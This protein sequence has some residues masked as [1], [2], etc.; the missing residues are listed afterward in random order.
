MSNELRQKLEVILAS[1][2][3]N[4]GANK[5]FWRIQPRDDEGQWIEMGA[6]VLFRFRTGDGNLVVATG[7][8]VYVGPS[9]K[10]GRARVMIEEGND[11]GLEPGIYD[12]E[13]RNLQQFQALLPE[14][15]V[16]EG[17][18]ERK[19]KFGRPVK[20]LADG[21]LPALND[22]LQNR[23]PITEEDRRLGRGELTP[24]EREAEADGREKSPIANLP[25]GFEAENPE[26][27]K[28][29]LR[30]SGVDPDEFDQEVESV[31]QAPKQLDPIDTAVQDAYVNAFDPT[32]EPPSLD[33]V[34]EKSKIKPTKP[35]NLNIGDVVV[36]RDGKNPG[37]ILGLNLDPSGGAQPSMRLQLEDGRII[38]APLDLK[39]E[40]NVVRDRVAK[41]S[42]PARPAAREESPAEVQEPE[43]VDVPETT[44]AD[45]T[46][47]PEAPTEIAP[48]GRRIDD[49]ET[50]ERQ[51][52]T[53]EQLEELRKTK[54]APLIDENGEAV[55]E[56][57]EKGKVRQPRDPNAMLN[58][59]ADTYKNSKFNDR[60][61]LVLMRETSRENGKNI[62]WEIR[63]AITGDKKI[64]YIFNF[65]N[66]DTGEEQTLLH[67][68]ARDSV[69]SLMGKTNSPEVLAD[70]LTGKQ[71]RKY[72]PTFDTAVHAKDVLER[73]L[74]F[75]YQGRTKS[76][77]DSAKYYSIGYAERVNPVNGTLLEKEVP[78]VFDAYSSKDKD[79]LASRLRAVF[80]GL[81]VDEQTHEE[82][83][84]A[85]RELFAERFPDEDKRQFGIAVTMA[86]RS[87]QKGL[88]DSPENRAV[89]WSSKDK[90][91]SLD[92]GQTVE[93]KNN[94][95]E[96]SI[97][98]VVGKQKVNTA[99][100]AQS[101]DI[102][103][104][105]DYVTVIDADGKRTSLPSTSLAILRDQSTALTSYKGRVSGARLREERGVFYTPGT[106]KF[107]GQTSIPD[108]ISKVDDLV[109]GDNFYNR[110]GVNLGTV[111]E[112][113]PIVGKDDKKGY[114]ILY[115]NRDGELRKAAVA[116]G[117]ER[118]PR[119][120]TSN[121]ESPTPTRQVVPDIEESDPDFDLD[122][123]EFQTD[124][125]TV[126]RPKSVGLD[127][128]VPANSKRNAEQQLALN[129]EVQ[130]EIDEMTSS[131]RD[132][133]TGWEYDSS[134]LSAK[135]FFNAG[136]LALL[137]ENA[138]A[139]YPDLTDSEIRTLLEL[140]HSKQR[141]FFGM[142]KEKM[143]EEILKEPARYQKSEGA[144]R[145]IS[146]DLRKE[147]SSR[148]APAFTDSQLNEYF[149]TIETIETFLKE[150]GLSDTLGDM[151]HGIRL[152]S[153]D[154]KFR[155]LYSSIGRGSRPP[156]GVL[157]VNIA[158]P[159]SDGKFTTSI[160]VNNESLNDLDLPEGSY[161]GTPF[162]HVIAHEYGH[163]IQNYIN[164]FG[165]KTNP[166]YAKVAAEKITNYGETSYGEHFAESFSRYI[167]TG[168]A[169]P[170]FL[171]FL[172]ES[173]ILRTQEN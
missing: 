75:K 101:D 169:T 123:I 110:D 143:I 165:F 90:V 127:F 29:L 30:E 82:A 160:L 119:F 133:F 113:V 102:F 85:I 21:Q 117:E 42:R 135:S 108:K 65:K 64:A 52:I 128:N 116:S 23:Q 168:E 142:T 151:S 130:R 94:I 138:R 73:A 156:S 167:Q 124:P 132:R 70:I 36:D 45:V 43:A 114:G 103:D 10:P 56:T 157:G 6:N 171:D 139:Q 150:Q 158:F 111:I 131:L 80:G 57:D 51:E 54:L 163:T 4:D 146:V 147:G 18:G 122:T 93:Y 5:G 109:P 12:V 3:F 32:K 69:Q 125:N 31:E 8:G 49:G 100:P 84:T 81:P 107:P 16:P 41:P 112:S 76:V 154:S 129:D 35:M 2:G 58:F 34:V 96:I 141:G 78:S 60:D 1:I 40:V 11:A 44:P 27:V 105:G 61:Q 164:L 71:T 97:V 28:E 148:L 47:A 63:A 155:A 9:G 48:S 120:I 26:E 62:Q 20:T 92:V 67:K 162:S 19:D 89:P 86:S 17:A 14:D 134:S 145:N 50:I 115:M 38:N 37:T 74:Y 68:D 22:L 24:E 95:G 46:D 88:L 126:E 153:S 173:G 13:S 55:L 152:V 15:A 25:A 104:Y 140:K 83:R 7:R 87:V 172:R 77:A 161:F 170:V 72:S 99:R 149:G 53:A 39:N 159:T 91:T 118:G 79:A 121:S 66:L 98:R 33:E 166:A 137:I 144:I 136:E 106:L 59:L